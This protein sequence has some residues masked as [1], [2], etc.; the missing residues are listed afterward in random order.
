MNAGI[1]LSTMLALTS[2]AG[3]L[4]VVTGSAKRMLSWRPRRPARA[5]LRV[6][7]R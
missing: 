5:R 6:R 4:M 3:L 7:R 1:H 2:A